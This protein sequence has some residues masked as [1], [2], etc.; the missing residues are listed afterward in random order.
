M[1]ENHNLWLLDERL[2][3]H[4]FANSDIPLSEIGIE[5]CDERPDILTF[6][7]IGPDRIAR[8]I[9]IIELK[10]PQRKEYDED[11]VK[12]MLRYVRKI[13][14]NRQV[15]HNGRTILTDSTTK[16]YC[17]AICDLTHAIHEY[18]ENQQIAKLK[19]ELG[20]YMY[21]ANFNSHIE[22]IAYDKL[23]ADAIQRNKMFFNMLGI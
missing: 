20:Y 18:A 15:S 1:Y 19:G 16:F 12:Q 17:Y 11:P 7:E 5:G 14:E 10:R 4:A 21:N 13:R 9:S 3:F 8:S 6:S 23:I 22:I 2:S